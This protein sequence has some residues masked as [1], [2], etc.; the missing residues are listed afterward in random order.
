MFIF[1]VKMFK[2]LKFISENK[3]KIWKTILKNKDRAELQNNRNVDHNHLVL[4]FLQFIFC[5]ASMAPIVAWHHVDLGE[6]DVLDQGDC[7]V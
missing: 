4:H 1:G 6:D 3:V 2:T 7:N 5:Q